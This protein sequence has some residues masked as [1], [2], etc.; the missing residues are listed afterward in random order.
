VRERATVRCSYS[1]LA[2]QHG[3]GWPKVAQWNSATFLFFK[4]LVQIKFKW[5]LNF[6]NSMDLHLNLEFGQI[7]PEI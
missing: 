7:N 2:A 4:A 3:L 1:G 5:D 6:Q